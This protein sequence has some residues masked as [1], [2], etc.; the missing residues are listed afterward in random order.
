MLKLICGK[1]CIRDREYS[2]GLSEQDLHLLQK[3]SANIPDNA[4]GKL[5]AEE[6]IDVYKRQVRGGINIVNWMEIRYT[7]SEDSKE[8]KGYF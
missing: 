5:M 3:L 7:K 6:K 1:M 2:D 4:I 8:S